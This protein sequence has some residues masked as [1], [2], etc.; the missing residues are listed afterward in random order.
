V[1]K[2]DKV[3]KV[4]SVHKVHKEDK[5]LKVQWAHKVL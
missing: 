2:E 4:M 1:L 5:V 3:L